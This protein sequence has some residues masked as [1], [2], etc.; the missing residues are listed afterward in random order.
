M[1]GQCAGGLQSGELLGGGGGLLLGQA[2][3][4]AG[5]VVER[6]Q[7]PGG[8]LGVARLVEARQLV[9]ERRGRLLGEEAGLLQH[10]GSRQLAFDERIEGEA[11]GVEAAEEHRRRQRGHHDGEREGEGQSAQRAVPAPDDR[12][13]AARG[14]RPLLRALRVAHE[15]EAAGARRRVEGGEARRDRRRAP[16]ADE[17]GDDADGQRQRGHARGGLQ[18]RRLRKQEAHAEADRAGRDRADG[19]AAHP[20]VAHQRG[21]QHASEPHG[22]GH[23]GAL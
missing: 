3:H 23:D 7:H 10:R 12:R 6:L 1:F 22:V 15:K 14:G 11:V 2:L 9:R 18:R 4:V 20:G 5:D 21:A 8:I 13:D 16:G 17:R 19:E